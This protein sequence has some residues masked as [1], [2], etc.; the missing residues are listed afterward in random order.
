MALFEGKTPA[1]RNKMIAAMV[2]VPAALLSVLYLLFGGG[3][4]RPAPRNTNVNAARAQASPPPT[5]STRGDHLTPGD[6]RDDQIMPRPLIASYTPPDVPAPERNI[7]AFYVPPPTPSPTPK[8]SPEPSPTPPP[9]LLL[10]AISPANVYARQSD[11]T[12]EVSGDKF[13]PAVR[14][15]INGTEVPTRY[16]NPQQLSANVPSAFITSEGPRQVTVRTPDGKL[17]SNTA[18]LNVAAAPVPNFQYIGLLGGRRYNDTAI[19]KDKTSREIANV[20]R[21]GVVGGRFRV[22]SI[23]EREITLIDTNL[24]IKHTIPFTG[25]ADAARSGQ[26]P[27]YQP[28]PQVD[29]G[30]EEP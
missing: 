14:I 28:P 15:S 19:L 29:E 3:S 23:S 26:Q 13:T 25:D 22:T 24:R 12:L 4:S 8:P 20:Q 17:Y 9:P 6:L 27:R 5:V 7:F 30:G 10:A 1:E 21:G 18:T 11:F 2:L 16:I